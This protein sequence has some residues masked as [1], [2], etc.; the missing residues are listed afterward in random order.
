[1]VKQTPT[2][3]DFIKAIGVVAI[4]YSSYYVGEKLYR[5]TVTFL[6]NVLRDTQL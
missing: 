1:M 2:P 4:I 5:K 6:Q 3:S